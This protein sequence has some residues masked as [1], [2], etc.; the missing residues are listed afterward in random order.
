MLRQAP[1]RIQRSVPRRRALRREWARG[2]F[3]LRLDDLEAHA[4]TVRAPERRI[5]S[6][7][8]KR[9]SRRSARPQRDRGAHPREEGGLSGYLPAIVAGV[10]VLVA[11]LGA[12]AYVS[13][14]PKKKPR[15]QRRERVDYSGK[16]YQEG[17]SR[18]VDWIR[19]C[20]GK[21]ATEAQRRE[22]ADLM[23]SDYHKEMEREYEDDFIRGF[24]AATRRGK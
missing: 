23:T 6:A 14:K 1:E 3:Q 2:E 21:G 9:T 17:Y 24:M 16:W 5:Q 20:A 13:G 11:L 8:G 19:R 10:V 22:I 12:A 15:R 4:L 7:V 18:G